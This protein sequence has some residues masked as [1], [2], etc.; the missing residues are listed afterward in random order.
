MLMGTRILSPLN[1]DGSVMGHE[2]Y[3]KHWVDICISCVKK[4]VWVEWEMEASSSG[5]K[6]HCGEKQRWVGR[7]TQRKSQGKRHQTKTRIS[8]AFDLQPVEAAPPPPVHRRG[9]LQRWRSIFYCCFLLCCWS[10]VLSV[11][12]RSSVSVV[13]ACP[14]RLINTTGLLTP[15]FGKNTH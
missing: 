12:L 8:T 4:H 15:V 13:V 9:L 5:K 7:D 1:I 6:R 10:P 14:M 2:I 3:M 11:N